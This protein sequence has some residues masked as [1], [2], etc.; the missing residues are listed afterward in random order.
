MTSLTPQNFT[1]GDCY[2]Q[3]KSSGFRSHHEIESSLGRWDRQ[4]G[5][6]RRCRCICGRRPS[7]ISV[8][9]SLW[10][11]LPGLHQWGRL[12]FSLL[13]RRKI[14]V[15]FLWSPLRCL[16]QLTLT[17]TYRQLKLLWQFPKVLMTWEGS[18][19][20]KLK[21]SQRRKRTWAWFLR[22]S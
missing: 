14:S 11:S 12:Q 16:N 18:S 2:Y 10:A 1:E 21:R 17:G 19:F 7:S 8:S 15:V 22:S 6:R 9:A 13:H 3:G 4:S 20:L 5:Q